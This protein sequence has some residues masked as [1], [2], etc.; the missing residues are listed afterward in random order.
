[1]GRIS[2]LNFLKL[3][4]GSVS[5]VLAASMIFTPVAG[6]V[7]DPS[8][9]FAILK[10]I[11]VKGETVSI[12]TDQAVPYNVFAVSSPDRLVV[13]LTNTENDWKKKELEVKKG[14]LISKVRSGQFQND[15]VKIARVVIEP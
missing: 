1:M 5:A 6:A 10:D 2:G 12:E 8:A 11:S 9:G 3:C 7:N 14:S 13:E 4:R 15:P